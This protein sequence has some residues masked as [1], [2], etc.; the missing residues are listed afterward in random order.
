M[1]SRKQKPH[2]RLIDPGF[3]QVF[4]TAILDLEICFSKKFPHPNEIWKNPKNACFVHFRPKMQCFV[5]FLAENAGAYAMCDFAERCKKM[6]YQ[7]QNLVTSGVRSGSC[8]TSCFSR[9][10]KISC[11]CTRIRSLP[12][13]S[14]KLGY[15][16]PL[17]QLSYR[18]ILDD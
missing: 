16:P 4:F 18:R 8:K 12:M 2:I 7:I 9:G 1:C 6:Q 17:Y 11:N 15:S 10:R 13:D 14:F 5:Q 3:F